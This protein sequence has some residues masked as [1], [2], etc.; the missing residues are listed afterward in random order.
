MSA[1][2]KDHWSGSDQLW[3]TGAKPG[4]H[5]E[6][7]IPVKVAGSY[8]VETVFTRARDYGIVQLS[9]DDKKLGGPLDFFNEPDVIT[10]GVL[11]FDNVELSEGNH[12]LRME[13]LGAHPK[14]DKAYMVGLD[15]LRL[16]PA[17]K[18]MD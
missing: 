10:T 5:L 18:T 14:A 15:Y 1:F 17:Q 12:R 4:D 3:W 13:I 7:E 2:P 11:S 8:T 6:L 9:L 16:S